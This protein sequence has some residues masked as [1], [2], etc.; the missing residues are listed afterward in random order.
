MR[1]A[2]DAQ[3]LP[4]RR[5]CIRQ[6]YAARSEITE[7]RACCTDAHL[8]SVR[9]RRPG[10]L[11]D[12][13]RFQRTP[14]CHECRSL[15]HGSRSENAAPRFA[16]SGA[17]RTPADAILAHRILTT[18]RCVRRRSDAA[19]R[20]GGAVRAEGVHVSGGYR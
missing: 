15:P 1:R 13:L 6:D 7:R 4:V 5:R 12:I 3:S 8:Q 10:Q 16:H 11:S 2:P 14:G 9:F 18:G 19:G 20:Y 17:D